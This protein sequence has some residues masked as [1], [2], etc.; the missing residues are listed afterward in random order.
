MHVLLWLLERRVLNKRQEFLSFEEDWKFQRIRNFFFSGRSVLLKKETKFLDCNS[1]TIFGYTSII[2]IPKCAPYPFI[3]SIFSVTSNDIKHKRLLM[4]QQMFINVSCTICT[5]H[6]WFGINR[7]L[8]LLMSPHRMPKT[9]LPFSLDKIMI[10][11]IPQKWIHV[12]VNLF[13]FFLS[14]FVQYFKHSFPILIIRIFT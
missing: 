10:K 3:K 1:N 7:L 6:E 4:I 14:N 11:N 12:N 9:T 2:F 13:N 5:A 8:Y